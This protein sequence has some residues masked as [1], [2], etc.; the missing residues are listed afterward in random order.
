MPISLEPV[1][2]AADT[3]EAVGEK[4]VVPLEA[5]SAFTREWSASLAAAA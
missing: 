2:P 3:E 1:L 5:P 4:V